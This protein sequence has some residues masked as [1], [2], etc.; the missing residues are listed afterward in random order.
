MPSKRK[1]EVVDPSGLTDVDWAAIEQVLRAFET[2][3]A[4]AFWNELENLGDDD[5]ILQITVANAFF[6]T[7]TREAFEDEMEAQGVT[8]EDLREM[9]RRRESHA[10]VH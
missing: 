5:V 10:A 6:P 2:G 7:V 8:I 3:G 9:L 4:D 1:L